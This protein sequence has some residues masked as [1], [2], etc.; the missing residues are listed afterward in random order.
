MNE[1]IKNYA[2]VLASGSGLRFGYKMPKQ[3]AKIKEKTIFE[4]SIEAFEKCEDI[5]Y[6][7]VVINS[8]YFDYAQ[9]IINTNNYKKIYKLLKGGDTRQK[10][11]FIGINSLEDTEANV[12]IHD[13][14]RPLLSNQIITKCLYALEEHNAVAVGIPVTDT[15]WEIDKNGFIKNIPDRKNYKLAQTPQCFK[16]SLIKKAHQL[17]SSNQNYTDDCSL[18]ID[19]NLDKI[20]IVDGDINNIKITYPKDLCIAAE[21]LS[22][23]V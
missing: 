2:I 22:D 20:Y 15:L 9:N 11:S 6:I 8:D 3:F 5:D 21:I 17:A 7:V 23:N 14:A 10:S 18:I 12:L 1:R 19:N 13:C 4:Y 16:L